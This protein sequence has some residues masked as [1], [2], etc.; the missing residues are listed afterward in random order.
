MK[1]PV[2]EECPYFGLRLLLFL[3]YYYQYLNH[4]LFIK[5]D[6]SRGY[7]ASKNVII[8]VHYMMSF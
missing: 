6:K 2:P 5:G 8:D 4:H 1:L 7:D 3:I